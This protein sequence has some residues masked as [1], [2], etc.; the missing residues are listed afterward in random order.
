MSIYTKTG[1][2]GRTLLK[3]GKKV[4][5]SD[6]ILEA[7]GTIDELN[8]SLGVVIANI[9]EKS[10]KTELLKIQSD[11]F[12]IGNHLT[13][14]K[15]NKKYGVFLEERIKTFEKTIDQMTGKLKKIE[16]FILPG[17]SKSASFLHLARTI[18]RR[19]ER[20]VVEL[21]KKE[22]MNKEAIIYLNRLSDLLFT[23]A[24]FANK[25]DKEKEVIWMG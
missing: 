8:S 23:M 14:E 24:R 4:L 10:I 22:K 6:P 18:C 15:V 5:K 21:S 25:I 20:K 1:D 2:S 12:E 13:E 11:L 17:G 9:K 16:H 19:A 3:N 7:H